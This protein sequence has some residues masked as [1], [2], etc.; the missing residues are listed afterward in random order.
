MRLS[1]ERRLAR[2]GAAELNRLLPLLLPSASVDSRQTGIL[3]HSGWADLAC[4]R[5][6]GPAFCVFLRAEGFWDLLAP[7]A[8][9]I[10]D[11]AHEENLLRCMARERVL[12]DLLRVFDEMGVEP[13]L[14]KG[15]AFASAL[16]PSPAGRLVGDIDLLISPA[17]RDETIS[18]LQKAGF[19]LV[20]QPPKRPGKL[21]MLAR[22]AGE[23]CGLA[24]AHAPGDEDDD[25]EAVFLARA[26]GEDILIE[27]H[28]YLIN[29]R[30]GGGKAEV[31]KSR[32]EGLPETR[33]IELS[34]GSVRALD[35]EAAFLHALRHVALHHRLIGLRWHHDLAL[36]LARWEGHLDPDRIRERC[37]GLNSEKILDVELAVLEDLFGPRVFPG[38]SREAWR[39]GALPWEFPLYRFVARGG[40]RTPLRELVRTFLAPRLR[41]QLQTLT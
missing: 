29:L 33:R 31:F 2:G 16:Y 19:R 41:E 22:K 30:A 35:Y 12:S 38:G 14:L 37:C 11:A 3:G 26:A 25:T 7:G 24:P 6:L 36:M 1:E 13:A 40:K 32:E 39:R 8:R 18:R 10:L 23:K 34:A 9:E 20:S 5:G 15:L 21:K 4:R 28:S 17:A 27:I